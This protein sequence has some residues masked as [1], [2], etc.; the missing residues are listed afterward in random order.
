MSKTQ[1]AAAIE[2][3]KLYA[4]ERAADDPTKLAKAVRIVRAGLA[5]NRLTVDDL[6][7]PATSEAA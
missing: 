5:R 7:P 3:T 4:A 2:A 1:T 6:L